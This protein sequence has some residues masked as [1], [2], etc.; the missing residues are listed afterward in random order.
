MS[1]D[2]ERYRCLE[3]LQDWK[4]TRVIGVEEEEGN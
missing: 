2:T 1:R 3:L 4:A